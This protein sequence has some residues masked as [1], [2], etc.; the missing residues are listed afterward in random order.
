MIMAKL[1]DELTALKEAYDK[2]LHDEGEEAVKELFKEFFDKHPEVEDVHWRQY[3]P[4][5]ND[6]D[7]CYFS[8]HEMN[9]T[10]NA[11]VED[12]EEDPG[13][14]DEEDE[15]YDDDYEEEADG[16]S[17]RNSEDPK[18]KQLGE[19]MG[20]LEDIPDDVLE[21]VFGDHVSITATREGFSVN[22]YDHD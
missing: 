22:E 10:L 20:V 19:D 3:T 4:Y 12:S 18:E 21:Y 2:K 11:P 9:L 7:P 6:G 13:D 14:E 15:D 5:F 8:V 1:F 16:W 17:L